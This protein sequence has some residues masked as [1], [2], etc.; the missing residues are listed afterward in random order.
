MGK[1][2]IVSLYP[3]QITE[4]K[5]GM[6]PSRYTIQAAEKDDFSIL[7]VDD[8]FHYVI[9]VGIEDPIRY[10]VSAEEIAA[11]IIN[12]FCSSFL[13]TDLDSKPGMFWVPG[14]E[15]K[16]VIKAKYSK[17]LADAVKRQDNWYRNLVSMADDTWTRTRQNR[18]ISGL[19][20]LAAKELGVK[21]DWTS[22]VPEKDELCPACKVSVHPDAVICHNCKAIINPDK[23]KQVQFAGA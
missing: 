16:T 10:P 7:H 8:G 6:F 13:A 14:H 1:A 22:I 5:H 17:E 19:Q 15:S 12:D 23:I 11:S 2:T 20:R 9:A 18:A 3:E 21:R 4:V